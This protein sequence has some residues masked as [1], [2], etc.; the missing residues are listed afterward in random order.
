M[1]CVIISD[2]HN[3]HRSINLPDG[4]ILIHCGDFTMGGKEHEIVEFLKWLGEVEK[5]YQ[6]VFIVPGNHDGAIVGYR[7]IYQDLLKEHTKNTVDLWL[8]TYLK[9]KVYMFDG[10]SFFGFPYVPFHRTVNPFF[11]EED[12]HEE[13][14]DNIPDCN[15]LVSHGPPLGYLDVGGYYSKNL[16]SF[17]LKEKILN[18]PDLKLMTF[19]HI[20]ECGGKEYKYKDTLLVNAALLDYPA[21][22]MVTKPVIVTLED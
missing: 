17:A 6:K 7:L 16:G 15:I 2:S 13:L 22:N 19:G 14:V 21:Y 3:Q 20:H 8:E 10:Y 9:N 18:M 1:K 12:A 4:D 11:L 5:R